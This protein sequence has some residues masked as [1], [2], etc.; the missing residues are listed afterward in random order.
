MGRFVIRPP[1]KEGWGGLLF[2]LLI[3]RDGEVFTDKSP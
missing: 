2:A 3:R 1:D